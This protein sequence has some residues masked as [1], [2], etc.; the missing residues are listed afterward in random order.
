MKSELTKAEQAWM[1]ELNRI[2]TEEGM[3][4]FPMQPRVL[5][6]V[7]DFL[8]D[9]EAGLSPREAIERNKP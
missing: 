6:G 1:L 9:F 8:S 5:Y 7:N 4:G 3:D 2:G